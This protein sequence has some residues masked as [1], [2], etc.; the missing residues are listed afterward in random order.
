VPLPD[1]GHT[2]E[3]AIA[4]TASDAKR[5]IAR[6]STKKRFTDLR[7]VQ[8]FFLVNLGMR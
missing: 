2:Y 4:G 1:W 8:S 5:Q 6:A 3:H 7:I